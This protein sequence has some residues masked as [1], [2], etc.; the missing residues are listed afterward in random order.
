MEFDILGNKLLKDIDIAYNEAISTRVS[1]IQDAINEVVNDFKI[2]KHSLMGIANLDAL[3]DYSQI[4]TSE[5]IPSLIKIGYYKHIRNSEVSTAI[6][7]IV[8]IGK[9]NGLNITY[10]KVN[11]ES[12]CKLIQNIAI[13]IV[14]SLPDNFFNVK[15][16]DAS[17]NGANFSS[18]LAL[19]KVKPNFYSTENTIHNELNN[20]LSELTNIQTNKL[21]FKY[22]TVEKYNQK[23]STKIPYQVLIINNYPDSFI[24][25]RDSLS[26]LKK[27]I[28]NGKKYGVLVLMTTDLDLLQKN[29]TRYS[30]TNEI[31]GEIGTLEILGDGK[32]RSSRIKELDDTF[33][34]FSLIIDSELPTKRSDI[35]SFL[36]NRLIEF[37]KREKEKSKNAF[38]F[39]RFYQDAK[40]SH[41][42]WASKSDE[43]IHIPLGFP[44]NYKPYNSDHSYFHLGI[45]TDEKGNKIGNYHGLI[46]G[47][48][49]SGKSVLINNL[50]INSCYYYSPEELQ[51]IIIDLK[52]NE[53]PEYH[54]LPHIKVLFQD[55]SKIDI[56]LNVLDYIKS[57]YE[58]RVQLFKKTKVNEFLQYRTKE[59]LPRLVC[60]IDEFQSFNQS[61]N[62]E[63]KRKSA[64]II[65]LIVGKGRAYGIHLILASQ[66][67]A[68]VNINSASLTNI[69][70]RLVLRLDEQSG[71]QI[72]SPG[73]NETLKFPDLQLVYNNTRGFEKSDNKIIKLPFLKGNL[74]IPHID[75][76]E[77]KL[78]EQHN[79][80]K[81]KYLLPGE[82]DVLLDS[83]I[84]IT[85]SITSNQSKENKM[86]LGT[87]YFI[88]EE[89]NYISFNPES[90]NN[91]LMIGQ[92]YN[93]AYRLLSV[94]IIQF[95][96]Y[97]PENKVYYLNY[98]PKSSKFHSIFNMLNSEKFKIDKSND[99]EGIYDLLI[100]EITRRKNIE[101][102]E[103]EY[104]LVLPQLNTDS[105]LNTRMSS[106]MA[107][108][109]IILETG[110]SVGI[111][112]V[113]FVESYNALSEINSM[114]NLS[115]F[116]IALRGGDSNR[117]MPNK[118]S[119]DD[120]GFVYLSAPTPYTVMNPD[121][122]NVFNSYSSIFQ[123]SDLGRKSVIEQLFNRLD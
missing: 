30:F 68:N 123:I 12:G 115:K 52:G 8:D 43:Y 117:I 98:V 110:P 79:Y 55:S 75:Y 113:I 71:R 76:F 72:L 73:N 36:N 83:N 50:I 23:E 104:L 118:A 17:S 38:N 78:T 35:I 99:A 84:H 22:Q 13:R 91:L 82:K 26:S 92:D 61:D 3:N 93:T 41:N 4:S 34:N 116:K 60:I 112:S 114:N 59:K 56:G 121:Y 40:L 25:R 87:P 32:F 46:G 66:S 88:K 58:E 53:Y 70:F 95:K 44:I 108:I 105:S 10:T 27:I 57:I 49:G 90:E 9:S 37:E 74:I 33:E 11:E 65:D 39:E 64:E 18:L 89:D 97:N 48:T 69:N 29:T 67:L 85:E 103:S 21:S 86:Y 47:E 109:K 94:L 16:F 62:N 31:D 14:L 111:Y 28:E 24:Y 54:K 106:I 63:V 81:K 102:L 100:E 42:F 5:I 120:E 107:K 119:V 45:L 20:I 15:I 1:N 80:N 51:F 7:A 96:A 6:P 122:I 101:L 77:S 2:Q 19:D